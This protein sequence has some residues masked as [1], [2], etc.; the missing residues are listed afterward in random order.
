MIVSSNELQMLVLKAC[1]G[2][3]VPM[4]QAQEVAV[5][6]AESP[7]ALGA[8]LP[9]LALPMKSAKFDFFD[10]LTVQGAALLRDFSACA[11]AAALGVKPVRLCGLA[12]CDLAHALARSRGLSIAAEGADVVFTEQEA[13]RPQVSR[14]AVVP[15]IWQ[16]VASFAALTYVPETDASRLAGAG[17]GLSDND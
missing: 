16:Q 17:A 14:G 5:A 6:L 1:R 8:L 15:E 2:V 9:H 7:Q 13:V 3:G 12:A 11:D 4:G 10:G